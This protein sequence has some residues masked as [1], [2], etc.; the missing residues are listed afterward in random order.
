MG[1]FRKVINIASKQAVNRNVSCIY[2]DRAVIM[3]RGDV[4]VVCVF[5]CTHASLCIYH[6][7]LE[8]KRIKNGA[9]MR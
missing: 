4:F 3:V 1:N 7:L 9:L 8:I 5:V 2:H 6:D